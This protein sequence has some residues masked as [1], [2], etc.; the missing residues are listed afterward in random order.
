MK[1]I[2]VVF[3]GEERIMVAV[4]HDVRL[5]YFPNVSTINPNGAVAQ[6]LHMAKAMR[7]EQNCPAFPKTLDEIKTFGLECFIAYGQRLVD[8]QNVRIDMSAD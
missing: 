7:D 4:C 1:S 5:A 2:G 8:Y 3:L 6:L